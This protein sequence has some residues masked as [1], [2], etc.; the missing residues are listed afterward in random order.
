MWAEWLAVEAE[1]TEGALPPN[2][3]NAYRQVESLAEGCDYKLS[4]DSPPIPVPRHAGVFSGGYFNRDKKKRTREDHRDMARRTIA[5][6]TE[7]ISEYGPNPW[8]TI[9]LDLNE[10]E[11]TSLAILGANYRYSDLA[12][13]LEGQPA[14]HNPTT[15]EN[16]RYLDYAEVKKLYNIQAFQLV[17]RFPKGLQPYLPTGKKYFP[18]QE[19]HH[20]THLRSTLTKLNDLQSSLC[21]RR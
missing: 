21:R 7:Q 20:I 15:S 11:A 9:Q 4:D 5:S 12:S 6:L 10:D 13:Y 17:E 2:P 8:A 16:R 18:P 19:H 1:Y 14:L 3:V